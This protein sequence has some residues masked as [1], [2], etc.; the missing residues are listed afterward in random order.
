MLRKLPLIIGLPWLSRLRFPM[1]I[2]FGAR[3]IAEGTVPNSPERAPECVGSQS[4]PDPTVALV[5]DAPWMQELW[6][7]HRDE[8]I[9]VPTKDIDVIRAERDY[10]RLHIG[11]NSFLLHRTICE[12]ERQLDPADFIRLHRSTIVRAD[13]IVGFKY[14]ANGS[15]SAHLRDGRWQRVGRTYLTNVRALAGR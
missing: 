7:L 2:I 3:R 5:P 6:V 14:S 15:W 4:R 8:I 9:R 1:G 10:M 12:L 13:F 11:L